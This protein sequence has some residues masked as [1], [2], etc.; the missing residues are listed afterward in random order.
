VTTTDPVGPF[1]AER[2]TYQ[3]SVA[4]A[5]IVRNRSGKVLWRGTVWGKNETF[6]RSYHIDNYQQVLSGSLIDAANNLMKN[7]AFREALTIG[8]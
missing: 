4:L 2:N 1:V 6:G 3:G 7:P 5:V 8:N